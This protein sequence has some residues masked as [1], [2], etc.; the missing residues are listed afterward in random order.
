[1]TLNEMKVGMADKVTQYVV[2]T[3][4]RESEILELLPFDNSVSPTG[5]GSTLTYGY[6]QK[7]L[8][9]ATAFRA[10]NTEY[11]PSQA[12]TEKKSVELKVFGGAFE[13]DRVLHESEGIYNNLSYQMEEKIKS[14]IGTFHN[15]MINGD[16]AV[17]ANEFDGLD[18]FL[19][20]QKTEYNADGTIDLSTMAL[21]KENADVFYEALLKL[22]NSTD[23]S[24]IM[25][26][27]GMKTKIQT[28]ARI[29][30]YK[31]ESEQAFGRTITTIGENNVRIIDLKNVVTVEGGNAVEKPVIGVSAEGMTDIFAVKFD[32]M[33]GF[34]GVT[35]TGNK[36]IHQYMPDF[37]TPG[38]VKKGEVEM[39]ACVALKN[40]KR[41]L[42]LP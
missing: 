38:A 12:T 41:S 24:A 19:V 17:N 39:V 16:A 35:I 11:A 33:N 18:K 14:A 15:A 7:K 29:L 31:T 23:A 13:M 36:A 32:V 9:S 1:M 28:V 8:P 37:N 40:V 5:G 6:V 3:F 30:G 10:I 26:N 25:C 20:G 4:I 42:H 34:H 22:I 2:D 27:E 21:L